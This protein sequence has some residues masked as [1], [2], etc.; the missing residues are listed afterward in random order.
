MSR[1]ANP[2]RWTESLLTSKVGGA[3]RT[4]GDKMRR[5][6]SFRP[7]SAHFGNR[8]ARS[9]TVSFLHCGAVH[10]FQDLAQ[11]VGFRFPAQKSGFWPIPANPAESG[12]GS[13]CVV[14][15]GPM[16]SRQGP[17]VFGWPDLLAVHRFQTASAPQCIVFA[18]IFRFPTAPP[19]PRPDDLNGT[20][21]PCFV[22]EIALCAACSNPENG[23]GVSGFRRRWA[24]S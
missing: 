20:L 7:L 24:D 21:R 9:P 5:S 11:I 6:P 8:Q 16:S 10:R 19:E 4:N 22:A 17:P 23:K 1:L 12:D 13:Q 3:H 18:L 2:K 14:L 15:S